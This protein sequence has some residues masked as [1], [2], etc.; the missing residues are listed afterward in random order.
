MTWALSLLLNNHE[1]LEK[2]QQELDLHIGRERQV[3]ESNMKNLVY[4]QL[5]SKKQC[6]YTLPQHSQCHTSL[7]KI[8]P[9][10]A[11]IS[12]QALGSLL[13]F[14]SS[15]KTHKCGQIQ[16]NFDWKISYKP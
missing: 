13:I 4:L 12:Q 16:A 5:F 15:I 11:T 7:L 10:L 14:Q 6:V 3:K 9:W 2:A 8:A 1:T